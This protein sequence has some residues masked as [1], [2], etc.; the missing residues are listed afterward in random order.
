MRVVSIG[1]LVLDYYYKDGKL[2]GVNGGMS[3]HN[4]IANLAKS[5]L[6][7]T[8]YGVCADD[9]QGKIAILSLQKLNVDIANIK[10]LNNIHTRC[11][12]VSYFMENGKINFISKK[13]CPICNEKRWY[14]ESLIDPNEIINN[15]QSDDILVFDNL[16]EKNIKIINNVDNKKIIDIGQYF[17]FEKLTKREIINKFLNKFDIINFNERVTKFL[18]NKLKLKNNIE[19]YNL[20]KPKLMTI[21][22]GENGAVFVYNDKEYKFS[23]KNKENF[24]DSNGAGDAFIASIVA[25]YIKN[26]F[27]CNENLFE[28]WFIN[29]NKLTSKVVSKVGARGHLNSLY[30]VRKIDNCCVC[31]NFNY[32]ERKRIKRCNININ[33]LEKRVINS[34]NSPAYNKLL[35]IDFNV[36]DNY[37]F[38]GT[39]GSFAG[40]MFASKIIN[41]LFG[42]NTYAL[43]PRDVLYRNNANINKTFLFSYSGTTNDVIKSVNDFDKKNIYIITKGQLQNI[44]KKTEIVK[45]NIICYRTSSNKGKERGFLSFEGAL[46]PASLFMKYYLQKNSDNIDLNDFIENSIDYWSKKIEKLVNIDFI[47]NVKN[48]NK[49]INIFRGDY[50]NCASYDL[51]SKIIESGIFNAIIHEKKN[52]SHGRFINYENMDNKCGIYFKQKTT[53]KYEEELIKYL[54]ENTIIIESRYDDI[55]AEFDLLI[56]SQFIIYQ[57][58]KVLDIDVSKPK[59]SDKAMKI[60]FYKGSL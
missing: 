20:L 57:I 29:S 22:R 15:I 36:N 41:N 10:I 52:F 7:T 47:N 9:E 5:G 40:A 2:L 17:E 48:H 11:F 24:V 4:I 51:E 1:D 59:Y 44:I 54:D 23:L 25:D 28:K 31:E 18:I 3:C 35:D 6:L 30:K 16:N 43:Y 8:V 46:A 13:R 42:S 58:G 14:E 56:A 27:E 50:A 19:L 39:G 55:F 34:V 49:I 32:T 12:N 53:S 33:N 45:D 26:N 37:L 21:T 38:I 60:Y